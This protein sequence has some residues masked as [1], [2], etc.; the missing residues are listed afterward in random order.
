MVH[1]HGAEREAAQQIEA[2][3]ALVLLSI[4]P[5]RD[6]LGEPREPLSMEAVGENQPAG[7]ARLLPPLDAG[8]LTLLLAKSPDLHV[9]CPNSSVTDCI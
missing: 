9:T 2:V 7:F 1:Y 5:V 3:V 8:R 6:A 4:A